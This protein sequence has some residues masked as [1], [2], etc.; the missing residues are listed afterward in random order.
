[1]LF[2]F[3][4]DLCKYILLKK[5]FLEIRHEQIHYKFYRTNRFLDTLWLNILSE[6]Y[7]S[8]H[9]TL[10]KYV[11]TQNFGIVREKQNTWFGNYSEIRKSQIYSNTK[12]TIYN[13]SVGDVSYLYRYWA[14]ITIWKFYN[15]IYLKSVYQYKNRLIFISEIN[16]KKELQYSKNKENGK[17]QNMKK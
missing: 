13:R 8:L 6:I 16:I 11:I 9:K 10:N 3:R 7:F 5:Y 12:V 15:Q 4:I 1:M 14:V 2:L 17:A